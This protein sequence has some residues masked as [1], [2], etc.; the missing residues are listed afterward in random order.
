MAVKKFWQEPYMIYIAV[1][2]VI[3]AVTFLIGHYTTP[4][5]FK[6][7]MNVKEIADIKKSLED[8]PTR[9]EI[10]PIIQNIEGNMK[11]IKEDIKDI[12]NL[13]FKAY[14]NPNSS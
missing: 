5:A 14:I 9:N 1:T 3:A 6:I 2:T 13:L 7:D 4:L 12:H 10:R 8:R 11:E